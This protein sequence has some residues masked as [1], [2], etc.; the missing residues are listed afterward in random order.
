M[1]YQPRKAIHPGRAI[2]RLLG[3]MGMSQKWLSERTGLTEKHI[4]K[5]INGEAA[6][7]EDTAVRL[8]NVLGGSAKFW[9][10]LDSNYRTTKAKIEQ[11]RRAAAEIEMLGDIPYTDLVNL[12][13]VEKTNNKVERVLNLWK[14]FGVNSLSQIPLTQKVAFRQTVDRNLNAY[15]L[16]AWLRKGEMEANGLQLPEYSEDRLLS[17]IRTIRRLTYDAPEDFYDRLKKIL[18]EAGVGLVAVKNPKNTSVHGATRWYG[19][20][21]LVQLSIHGKN[22]DKMW[23]SLFHEIGHIVKHGKREQFISFDKMESDERE[24][25]ANEF[26][27]EALLPKTE[28]DEFVSKCD[29]SITAVNKFASRAEISPDIIMGR[30]EHDGLVPYTQFAKNHAKLCMQSSHE[31]NC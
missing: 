21:P 28:F 23:F 10:N 22:A 2:E 25:E 16:A 18:Q 4:S 15:A 7:T 13:W 5:M 19:R 11:E 27:S 24:D 20:N 14:F 29:F 1:S 3:D 12:V 17:S 31:R 30:L 8:E 9:A 26:A 6:I